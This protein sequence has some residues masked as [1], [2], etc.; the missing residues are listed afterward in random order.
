VTE[1]GT[2]T[3]GAFASLDPPTAKRVL[4]IDDE[5]AIRRLVSRALSAH[6]IV[7][8]EA[9]DGEEGLR[10]ARS[11]S[12]DAILLDLLLPGLDGMTVLHALRLDRHHPAV[13]VFSSHHDEATREDCLGAGARDFLAKPF[14]L[15]DLCDRVSRACADPREVV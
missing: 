4:V 11:R 6:G 14:S 12:Y 10:R 15:V 9:G 2:T 5:D 8:D 13:V 3:E 7:V 1:G